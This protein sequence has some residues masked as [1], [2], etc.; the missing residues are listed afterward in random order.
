MSLN[1]AFL[2]SFDGTR[3]IVFGCWCHGQQ[4][5]YLP[6][7]KVSALAGPL[8]GF[9]KQQ[10]HQLGCRRSGSF[11][12]ASDLSSYL[13]LT[14]T[15]ST[16][17]LSELYKREIDFLASCVQYHSQFQLWI[18]LARHRVPK[19]SRGSYALD[20]VLDTTS[21]SVVFPDPRC[22][23]LLLYILNEWRTS[24]SWPLSIRTPPKC[25]FEEL[26]ASS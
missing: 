22:S 10:P 15:P 23:S 14:F 18:I 19:K 25:C 17:C 7:P 5:M 12:R 21:A 26:P 8:S 3:I 6:N 9:W 1:V 11:V 2:R 16:K 4:Y 24:R 13:E 20:L